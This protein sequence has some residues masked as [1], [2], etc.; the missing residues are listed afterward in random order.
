MFF[1]F[2]LLL[3]MAIFVFFI[4]KPFF[5]TI[6]TGAILSYMSFPLYRL[7]NKKLRRKNISALLTIFLVIVL[8]TVPLIFAM[9]S[10]AK[11]ARVNYILIKQK[12]TVGNF[13]KTDCGNTTLLCTFSEIFDDVT[14]A[15]RT[16]YYL[17]SATERITNFIVNSISGFLFSLPLIF[18]NLI[19]VFFVMFYLLRDGI[20]ILNR[21]ENLS[22]LKRLHYNTIIKR[23]DNVIFAVIFGYILIAVIEGV[24][25]TVI[26]LL[27]G[28]KAP[29]LLGLIIAFLAILPVAGP[30]LVWI[31]T[32]L[33]MIMSGYSEDSNILVVKGIIL[34]VYCTFL[35]TPIDAILKPKIIGSK[36]QVHPVLILLGVLGGLH[37]FGFIGFIIGP[38][39]LAVFMTFLQIYEKERVIK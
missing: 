11:E 38:V 27:L 15:P 21:I 34:T 32:A 20:H 26:F 3:A 19:I 13:H 35:I 2:V 1:F 5:L 9:N 37:M 4:I 17:D 23:F 6:I 24:L 36:A 16:K 12:L 22:P 30:P 33:F 29:F 10:I 14:S 8:V 18:M 31:P 28:V 7:I 25:A 39:I